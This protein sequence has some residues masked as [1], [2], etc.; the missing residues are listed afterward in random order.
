MR[1]KTSRQVAREYTDQTGDAISARKVQRILKRDD[2]SKHVARKKP[3][4]TQKHKKA[5]LKWARERKN[6][7]VKDWKK[8]IWS[9]KTGVGREMEE[10]E[11]VWHSV[12][13]LMKGD[14]LQDTTKSGRVSVMFWGCSQAGDKGVLATIPPGSL[15][16]EKYCNLLQER[17]LPYYQRS[18]EGSVFQQD[19]CCIHTS[20]TT[21]AWLQERDIKTM[22]WPAQ[23]PDL[24]PIEHVWSALKF[25]MHANHP[26]LSTAAG[27]PQ[28]VSSLISTCAKNA[29]RSLEPSFFEVLVQSMP[30]RVAAVIEA[31]GGSTKY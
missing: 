7:T 10:K 12:G 3:K 17:L 16:S 19:N 30:R 22:S 14:C 24:N 29:W 9:D 25:R 31:K 18:P 13:E 23:S 6:W 4:L 26:G 20:R 2:V 8:I 11:W 28:A 15:N 5:R 21:R 27:T 1:R